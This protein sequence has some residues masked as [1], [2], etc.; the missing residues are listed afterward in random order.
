MI[1]QFE[2]EKKM[3]AKNKNRIFQIKNNLWLKPFRK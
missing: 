2:E 3:A 1:L